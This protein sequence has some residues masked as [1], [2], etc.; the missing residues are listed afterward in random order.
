MK[1]EIE[2][3]MLL[4]LFYWALVKL[5]EKQ[6]VKSTSVDNEFALHFGRVYVFQMTGRKTGVTAV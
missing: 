4:S 6:V 5:F 2:S 3:F 1:T